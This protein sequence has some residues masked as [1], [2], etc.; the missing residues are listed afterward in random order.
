MPSIARCRGAFEMH[1][2]QLS[3]GRHISKAHRIFVILSAPLLPI[4][5]HDAIECVAERLGRFSIGFAFNFAKLASFLKSMQM[6]SLITF[7][8]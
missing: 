3:T 1:F 2:L 7:S 5:F 8:R 6:K 4:D